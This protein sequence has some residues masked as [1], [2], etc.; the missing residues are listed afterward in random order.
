MS[1]I[2]VI[3]PTFGRRGLATHVLRQLA[4]QTRLPDEVI[5]SAP[6][7]SHV[8][9][10]EG[11]PFTMS[12]AFGPAGL[13]SQRNTAMAGALGRCDFISFFDDDF[14]PADTYLEKLVEGFESHPEWVV[15]MGRV[16]KDGAQGE[17]ISPDEALELIRDPPPDNSPLVRHHPGAYGCNMAIRAAVVGSLRFDER[18][19]LYGWQEDIDF[20]HQLLRYGHVVYYREPS[21]VHLGVKGG[22][23][24]GVKMGYSQ[25]INP[26]YLMRK[27]TMPKGFALKLIGRNLVA[28]VVKSLRPEPWIDR[29]GRLFGNFVAIRH[30]VSGRIEP[31]YVL[32]L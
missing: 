28:N 31:E 4:R 2:I 26:I 17:A 6:D 30:L 21:G 27:G 20:T 13:C 3:I 16:L 12:Y 22:R 10:V 32:K 18:L 25:V 7:E 14:I 29:R 8:E 23:V 19:V 24:S 15:V 1:R 11:L 9:R 5:L